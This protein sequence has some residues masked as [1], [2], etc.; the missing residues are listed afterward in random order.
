MMMLSQKVRKRFFLSFRRI[1]NRGPGQAP[2]SS[3]Y[4]ESQ[5]IWTPVFTGVTTS[6]EAVNY[7]FGKSAVAWGGIIEK[8]W[9]FVKE[10]LWPNAGF[11]PQPMHLSLPIYHCSLT[12][13]HMINL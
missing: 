4:S 1:P 2:E 10:A 7:C 6:W 13:N 9:A 8:T 12:Q 3:P 5:G 11:L